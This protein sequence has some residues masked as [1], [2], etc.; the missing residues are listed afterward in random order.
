MKRG[1]VL[2]SPAHEEVDSALSILNKLNDM[3]NVTIG[4][5][6]DVIISWHYDADAG[7]G[8]VKLV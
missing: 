5:A 8:L 2:E 1:F 4:I 3:F 7:I 6:E